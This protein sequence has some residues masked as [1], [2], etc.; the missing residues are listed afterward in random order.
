LGLEKRG[1]YTEERWNLVI[2]KGSKDLKG[3]ERLSTL[4]SKVLLD[5]FLEKKPKHFFLIYMICAKAFSLLFSKV[6]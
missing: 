6:L 3:N 1:S 5:I 4:A 2:L